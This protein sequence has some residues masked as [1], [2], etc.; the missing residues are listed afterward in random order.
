VISSDDDKEDGKETRIYKIFIQAGK[1][2]NFKLLF[3]P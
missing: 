2:L 1:T 3:S